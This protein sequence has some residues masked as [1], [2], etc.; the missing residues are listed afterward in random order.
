MKVLWVWGTLTRIWSDP[1]TSLKRRQH[2]CYIDGV[3]HNPYRLKPVT[4]HVSPTRH[5]CGCGLHLFG[6]WIAIW[7]TRAVQR[8]VALHNGVQNLRGTLWTGLH[9]VLLLLLFRLLGNGYSVSGRFQD[10]W[11]FRS[12]WKLGGKGHCWYLFDLKFWVLE[13]WINP[14]IREEKFSLG[15]GS[16]SLLLGNVVRLL[17]EL[18][19]GFVCCM[20]A[21]R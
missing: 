18:A 6:W 21:Y 14:E 19:F 20:N 17:W 2:C 1:F 3:W 7:G 8:H 11:R 5:S 12:R 13:R 4:L 10:S 15:E 16:H 9:A